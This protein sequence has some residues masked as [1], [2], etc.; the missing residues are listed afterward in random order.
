MPARVVVVLDEPHFGNEIAEKLNGL[1]YDTVAIPDSM[2]A[3]DA[4]EN[5]TRVE[6]LIASVNFPAG[7]PNGVSLAL[8][9]RQRRPEMKVIF[10]GSLDYTLFATGLGEIVERPESATNIV[11]HA[12]R[13]LG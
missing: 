11:Q 4:F 5:A 8:L 1:G 12:I 13:L 3:L 10:I 6:L 2:A 7:R 9:A